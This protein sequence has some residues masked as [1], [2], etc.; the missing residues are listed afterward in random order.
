[1]PLRLSDVFMDLRLE[2]LFSLHWTSEIEAEYLKNMQQA[3]GFPEPA[4]RGR[5]RAMRRRCPE[6]EIQAPP[7]AQ[8]RVPAEV[9]SKDRHVAAAALNLRRFVDEE[10]DA[11]AYEVFLVTDNIR[12][13][14]KGE[15]SQLGVKVIRAGSFLDAVYGEHPVQTETALLRAV[16]DLTDPPYTRAELLGAIKG[17]GAQQLVEGLAA[18]WTVVPVMRRTNRT[19]IRAS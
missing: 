1:M 14:A 5:L 10:S 3:F 9:H 12:H 19:R 7:I 15:M 8:S 11:S 6:W 18:K 16:S 17:H 4:I 13:F 2:G